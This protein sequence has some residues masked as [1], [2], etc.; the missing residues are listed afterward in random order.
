MP[1]DTSWA[2]EARNAFTAGVWKMGAM[3]L[4]MAA[5]RSSTGRFAIAASQAPS[6][7][8]AR[9]IIASIR[10]VMPSPYRPRRKMRWLRSQY[11]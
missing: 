4:S 1:S 2:G 10:A 5:S 3:R 6:T 9:R 11:V 8:A 7:P